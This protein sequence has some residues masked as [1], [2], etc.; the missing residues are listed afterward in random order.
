MVATVAAYY[1]L[2]EDFGQT[3]RCDPSLGNETGIFYYLLI[4]RTT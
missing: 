4:E 2:I 1:V 3:E